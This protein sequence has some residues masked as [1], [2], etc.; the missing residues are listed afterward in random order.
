MTR[1]LTTG[2]PMRLIWSFALPT[3]F[4][5]LF[6]QFY[7]MMDTMIVGQLLGASALASVGSTSSINFFVIGFCMGVCNGFAIPV[8]QRMGA[9]DYSQMRRCVANAGWLS[10]LFAV[11]L[12]VFTGLFCRTIL[13]V[14][15]TPEDIFDG[16]YW[17]IL[18]IFLGIPTTFLYNL[19]AAVIRAL[20]DSKTPVYF[21][22]IS[23]VLNIALDLLLILYCHAGVAGAA[24]ATVI[25]QGVSGLA[26]LV[27]MVKR[28]PILHMTAEERRLDGRTCRTLCLMGIPMGLQYSITAIGSIVLQS[29]VNGLG[30]RYVASVA[31][32]T[33]L[34]QVICCP[35]DAMGATMA[36]YCGQNV[37]AIKLDR[38]GQGL[39]ACSL[40]GLGYALLSFAAIFFFAPQMALLFLNPGE[41][42]LIGYTAQYITTPGRL[43]LSPGPGEYPPLLHPGDG[44]QQPGHP[45]RRDG[46]VRPDGCG[47]PSGAR[48]RLYRSLLRLPRRLD[49]CRPVPHPRQ[50]L[51]YRPPPQ[52]LWAARRTLRQSR[53]VT[54]SRRLHAARLTPESHAHYA[55]P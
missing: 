17:Y 50:L 55:A 21:L 53:P 41:E 7:N 8:A 37:G 13:T 16:A 46:D 11:V 47:H 42:A 54:G 15:R 19:L 43:L 52:S 27:F 45:G 28:F 33:K 30:S 48:H 25:S 18:I 2:S 14:M 51:E 40:L 4:G 35:F 39:R 20:G 12:T 49:L 26:C 32:G 3:L 22:A 44:L 36:T 24:L 31:A 34:F 38:L 29:A 6:Q 5:M 1:D 9:G 23:S 10:A